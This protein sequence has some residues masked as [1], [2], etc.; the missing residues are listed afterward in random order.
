MAIHE[1][2]S[3]SKYMPYN[4]SLSSDISYHADYMKDKNILTH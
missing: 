4:N 1:L 3:D 2:L